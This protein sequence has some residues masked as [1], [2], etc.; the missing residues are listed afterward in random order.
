MGS[1]DGNL[2]VLQTS[3]GV[4]VW[5]YHTNTPVYLGATLDTRAA[6]VYVCI[7]LMLYELGASTGQLLRNFQ[8]S[9]QCQ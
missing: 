5:R 7:G 9:Q 6:V 2:Y 8:V 1:G 3:N 4:L